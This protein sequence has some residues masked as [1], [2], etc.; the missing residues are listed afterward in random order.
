MD[1]LINDIMG[2]PRRR[3]RHP[4]KSSH[5]ETP[6][7][8]RKSGSD[9]FKST[10]NDPTHITL[11]K[12]TLPGS[13]DNGPTPADYNVISEL[14]TPTEVPLP[15]ANPSEIQELEEAASSNVPALAELPLFELP[16]NRRP[17][18]TEEATAQ[19]DGTSMPNAVELDEDGVKDNEGTVREDGSFP[20]LTLLEPTPVAHNYETILI[21]IAGATA[22]G[23][24]LLSRLL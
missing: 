14:L 8:Q 3:S 9:P 19:A 22:S 10:L 11:P 15:P 18:L 21:G 12:T 17:S 16:T 5:H 7:I 6:P 24:T 4:T 23:K 1:T 13:F 20:P 2:P